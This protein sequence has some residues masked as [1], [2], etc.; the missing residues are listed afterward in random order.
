VFIGLSA[1]TDH[2]IEANLPALT[3]LKSFGSSGYQIQVDRIGDKPVLEYG[4]AYT[5]YV[6]GVGN[7]KLSPTIADSKIVFEDPMAPGLNVYK[8]V[9]PNSGATFFYYR[10]YA[11]VQDSVVYGSV[12]AL[13]V[14]RP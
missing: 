9:L 10:A 2:D 1:C 14:S 13:D 4:I 11:M 8:N 6:R 5:S 12:L 7:H 3:T